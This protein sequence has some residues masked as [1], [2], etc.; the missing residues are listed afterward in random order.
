MFALATLGALLVA[1]IL[2]LPIVWFDPACFYPD[3]REREAFFVTA[4][5]NAFIASVHPRRQRLVPA[6]QYTCVAGLLP[7]YEEAPDDQN[8]STSCCDLGDTSE[9]SAISQ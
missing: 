1:Y 6:Q 9:K 7:K 5:T 3:T 8:G 2:T 4:V